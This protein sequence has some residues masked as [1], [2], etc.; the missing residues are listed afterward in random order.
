MQMTGRLVKALLVGVR[1][2][3]L[4][5]QLSMQRAEILG[6]AEF[7]SIGVVFGKQYAAIVIAQ[8]GGEVVSRDPFDALLGLPVENAWLEYL[9]QRKGR[10][11]FAERL[12]STE[13]I[14]SA[15]QQRSRLGLSQCARSLKR[16]SIIFSVWR[17]FCCRLFPRARL[18]KLVVM[19][20]L[21]DGW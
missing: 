2:G 20:V 19:R 5:E 17:R 15:T 1:M 16:L 4:L 10:M 14:S 21:S 6:R 9:D 12:N 8:V 18:A 3:K 7:S 13:M 11:S